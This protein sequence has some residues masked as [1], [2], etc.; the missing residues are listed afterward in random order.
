QRK[1]TGARRVEEPRAAARLRASDDSRKAAKM[2]LS[3]RKSKG[4]TGQATNVAACKHSRPRKE[5]FKCPRSRDRRAFKLSRSL[6]PLG[7]W[8]SNHREDFDLPPEWKA[9]TLKRYEHPPTYRK[10]K[11]NRY[12]DSSLRGLVPID[13]IPLCHCDVDYGC[14][15]DCIK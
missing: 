4:K 15:A 7:V 3:V 6:L 5:L 13:E 8:P 11:A 1:R 2:A 10:L 14:D 9:S 12:A